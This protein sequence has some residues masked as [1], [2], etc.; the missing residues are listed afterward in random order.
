M[1][2]QGYVGYQAVPAAST[3]IP[4][5]GYFR[6]LQIWTDAGS[7][8]LYINP[9]GGTASVGGADCIRIPAGKANGWE[10]P[11]G[12]NLAVNSISVIGAAAVGNLN[13]VAV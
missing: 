7:A 9:K 11:A 12:A 1:S 5:N 6:A 4:L 2:M 13:V 3:N 10:S 8:D